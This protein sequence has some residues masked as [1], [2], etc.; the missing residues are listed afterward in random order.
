MKKILPVL[1]FALILTFELSSKSTR[2]SKLPNGNKFSCNTC[3]TNG[4]G[5]PRNEFG[6]AVEN[7]TGVQDIEFWSPAL[8]ALDS[9]GDGWTNGEELLDPQ[10]N[11]KSGDANPGDFN[12]VTQPGDSSSHPI[13]T[14]TFENEIASEYLLHNNYPNPF[15][16]VTTIKFEIPEQSIVKINVYSITGELVKTL[17]DTEV[18]SGTYFTKWNGTDEFN[19]DVSSGIYIYTLETEK[20]FLSKKMILL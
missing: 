12:D 10:G 4:G 8:A 9:D 19:S 3:H 14:S 17:T 13:L 15:N 1:I 18:F 20:A 6:Q 16:P 5:T 2:V 11:W 7:I